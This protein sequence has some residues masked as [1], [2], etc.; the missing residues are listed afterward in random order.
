MKN[1]YYITTSVILLNLIIA[2]K[3]VMDGEILEGISFVVRYT[4]FFGEVFF[5]IITIVAY[6]NL[7]Y[8]SR[9][10]SREIAN[11]R[12]RNQIWHE[13][14]DDHSLYLNLFVNFYVSL[15]YWKIYSFYF[16]N[17]R[18]VNWQEYKILGQTLGIFKFTWKYVYNSL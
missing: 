7:F 4:Q 14:G 17:C 12:R 8:F 9:L 10:K 18:S 2:I 3:V 5:I 1:L 16:S 15:F 11:Q 6:M 13:I